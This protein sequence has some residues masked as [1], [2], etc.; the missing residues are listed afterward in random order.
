VSEV[1]NDD[2]PPKPPFLRVVRGDATPEEVAALVAVLAAVGGRPAPQKRPV[3]GWS[4]RRR[5]VRVSLP[6][7]HGGWR[8]SALPR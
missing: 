6:N 3:P 5:H 7:R 4:D 1:S 2:L 8:A